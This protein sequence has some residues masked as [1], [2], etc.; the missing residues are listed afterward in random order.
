LHI[1]PRKRGHGPTPSVHASRLGSIAARGDH[2][3]RESGDR[4]GQYAYPVNERLLLVE[5]D[6]S[7]REVIAMGLERAGFHI[8]AIGDGRDGLAEF[9]RRPYDAV[10]LDLMLPSMDGFDVCRA[11]RGSSQVPIIILTARTD[12]VDVVVGLELGADD[13]ITK[14]FEVPELIARLRAVLRRTAG[15][16]GRRC[17]TPVT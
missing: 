4:P 16:S 1:A 8:T 14:P 13:Y 3:P 17:C 5:D 6:A 12:T 2:R 11:I 7:I 10:L 15:A 9:R